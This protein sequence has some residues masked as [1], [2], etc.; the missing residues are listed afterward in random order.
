MTALIIKTGAG[1]ID[2]LNPTPEQVCVE[3]MIVNLACLPRWIGAGKLSVLQHMMLVGRLLYNDGEPTPT[4]IAG[5]VHDLHEYATGDLPAPLLDECYV[6]D[7]NASCLVHLKTIQQ[8]IQTAIEAK[9]GIDTS[10]AD[11]L[12][13]DRADQL[14]RVQEQE[15]IEGLLPG[16][17]WQRLVDMTPDQAV[18]AYMRGLRSLGVRV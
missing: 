13:V 6:T 17:L 18:G 9:L 5:L 10:D 14:A 1:S 11:L 12:A 3:D 8:R 2:L 15:P 4:V 7:Y 16:T